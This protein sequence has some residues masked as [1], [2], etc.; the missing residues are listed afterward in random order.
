MNRECSKKI[1]RKKGLTFKKLRDILLSK[2][3]ITK[4]VKIIMVGNDEK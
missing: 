1:P 4:I 3:K 2:R